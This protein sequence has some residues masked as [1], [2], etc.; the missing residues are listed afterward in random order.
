MDA[1]PCNSLQAFCSFEFMCFDSVWF[2]HSSKK[3]TLPDVNS[4]TMNFIS[5][6]ETREEEVDQY[7]LLSFPVDK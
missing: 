2:S 7:C 3:Q 5:V 4:Q 1:I 6:F